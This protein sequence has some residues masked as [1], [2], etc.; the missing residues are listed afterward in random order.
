MSQWIGARVLH[1]HRYCS[2]DDS[3][4]FDES[5][6]HE[7]SIS[8]FFEDAVRVLERMSMLCGMMLITLT[9]AYVALC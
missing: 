3:L 4:G 8:D 1:S 2:F 6:E 5:Y 7:K 9:D